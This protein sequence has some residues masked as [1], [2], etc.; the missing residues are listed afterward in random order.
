MHVNF[1]VLITRQLAEGNSQV[2]HVYIFKIVFSI[3]V[4]DAVAN[5]GPVFSIFTYIK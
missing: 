2:R 1:G 4:C 3:T 5:L